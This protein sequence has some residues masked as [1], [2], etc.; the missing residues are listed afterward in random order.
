MVLEGIP[1]LPQNKVPKFFGR[2]AY[3]AQSLS[4][5]DWA[6]I[7]T[8]FKTAPN[9]Y[10]MLDLEGYGGV[11]NQYP[12]EKS[13]F[14]HRDVLLDFYTILFFYDEAGQNSNAQWMSQFYAFL[15]QYTNGHSYQNYPNRDQTNYQWAYWGAYYNQLVS[16][17]NN[18]DPNNFFRYPQSIGTPI[19]AEYEDKQI[20]LFDK[21]PIV[22]ENH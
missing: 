5:D 6:N 4:A 2:S 17:K 11:I 19:G 15:T 20:T 3:L 13:A 12:V 10:A 14:I 16:I 21:T 8:Q 18:Y 22:Y 7:L 9:N 1:A